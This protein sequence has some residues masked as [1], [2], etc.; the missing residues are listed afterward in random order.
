MEQVA[1]RERTRKR[2]ARTD[3]VPVGSQ[4]VPKPLVGWHVGCA[5]SHGGEVFILRKR[6]IDRNGGRVVR[7]ARFMGMYSP[8]FTC[9]T[10]AHTWFTRTRSTTDF[11]SA[12][13]RTFSFAVVAPPSCERSPRVRQHNLRRREW[14]CQ[15]SASKI[16]IFP[17]PVSL[18]KST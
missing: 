1:P 12:G 13:S 17:R 11:S 2:A 7:T 4:G 16:E 6:D 8:T 9:G 18:I 15:R 3:V 5:C 10:C 14:I